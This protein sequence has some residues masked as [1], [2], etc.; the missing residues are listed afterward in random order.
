MKK[1][2][3]I[4][5]AALLFIGCDDFLD[6]RP[7]G[8]IIAETGEE[9]RALLTDVYSRMPDERGLVNL[10]SDDVAADKTS[11][12]GDD[13]NSYYDIWNWTDSNRNQSSLYFGWRGYYH[14]CYIANYVIE[15]KDEITKATQ[16]EIDQMVGECYMIRAYVHFLLA[17]LYAP[18]YTHCEPATTRGVPLQ[19]TADVNAVLKCSSVEQVYKQIL[20]DIDTAAE[21]LNVKKWDEGLTYRFNT[22]TVNALRAR[23]ALYMGDWELAYTEAVKV[24][25][26]YPELED[27]NNSKALL[28]TNYK[29]VE[30]IMALERVIT[31]GLT[32]VGHIASDLIAEY[33]TG[34]ARKK[35]YFTQKSLVRFVLA[36][37]NTSEERCT[38]RSGEFYLIAA[39]AANEIENKEKALEYIKALMQKRYT[40]AKYPDYS[41]AL[42]DMDKDALREEIAKER[43]RE[44][45]FQGHRWFDLRRTTQPELKKVYEGEESVLQQGDA[46][47]T[48]RFPSEAVEANPGIEIWE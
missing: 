44:L 2:I 13:Y 35:K 21:Y 14:S 27:L 10:R 19:L 41:S 28:P 43:R 25:A 48:L 8:M 45:A 12:A 46:R 34:D 20:D 36:A 24:I 16:D 15:H 31:S 22:T 30:S 26:E 1:Y 37:R 4:I 3:T 18:A 23:V 9:Y 5:F 32:S 47:Y 11:L 39:E 33:R 7:T 6:I 29:S 38:F 40:A 17:N 42:D